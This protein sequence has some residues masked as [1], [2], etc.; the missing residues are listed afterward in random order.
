MLGGF[1]N[2]QLSRGFCGEGRAEVVQSGFG[3]EAIDSEGFFVE[4]SG[5][6]EFHRVEQLLVVVLVEALHVDSEFFQQADGF[7]AVVAGSFD[8]LGATVAEQQAV[9]GLEF[10]ALGVSTEIVVVVEE[11]DAS[12]GSGELAVKK[13]GGQ[14]TDASA[15]DD[16]VV[17]LV[18][19]DGVRPFLAVAQGVRGFPGAIVAAAHSGLGRGVVVGIF[20]GSEWGLRNA[21]SFNPQRVGGQERG[22]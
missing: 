15:D 11:Q 3:D 6:S 18:V 9:A 10:V 4:E 21:E 16:Q 12:I 1:G 8:G 17:G 7:F 14:A 20:L 22:P 13:G 19:G 5:F 2:G